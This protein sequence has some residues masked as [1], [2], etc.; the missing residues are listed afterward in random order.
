MTNAQPGLPN[1]P[2]PGLL[3]R[4]ES[5]EKCKFATIHPDGPDK[6]L[7]HRLPPTT[8]MVLLRDGNI[9]VM[10]NWAMVQPIHWCGEYRPKIEGLS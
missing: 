9:K 10:S 5:C 7:C 3:I 8:S 2:R 4:S 6:L 1:G